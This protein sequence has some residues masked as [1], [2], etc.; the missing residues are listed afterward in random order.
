MR[1]EASLSSAGNMEKIVFLNYPP[2]YKG[3]VCDEIINILTKYNVR[4]CFYGHLHGHSHHLALE[5]LWNG[6][7]YHLVAADKLNFVPYRII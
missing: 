3:Y 1:L 7:N 2:L 6:I 5:G 4:H